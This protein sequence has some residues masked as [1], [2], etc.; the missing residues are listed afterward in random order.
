MNQVRALWCIGQGAPEVSRQVWLRATLEE[1]LRDDPFTGK[2]IA[3]PTWM[4]TDAVEPGGPA[5]VFGIIELAT[6]ELWVP[7]ARA[8]KAQSSALHDGMLF[9]MWTVIVGEA[10]AQ[11]AWKPSWVTRDRLAQLIEF[12]VGVTRWLAASV[13]EA[14][15]NVLSQWLQLP[16]LENA[17]GPDASVVGQSLLRILTP[18]ARIAVEHEASIV[19][20]VHGYVLP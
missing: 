1:V 4:P 16:Y 5:K 7:A 20:E 13:D 19:A 8:L 2:A 11:S 6:D 14:R 17:G 12:P 15:D 9:E 3:V 18:L 10:A